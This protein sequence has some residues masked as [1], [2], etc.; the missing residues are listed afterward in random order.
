MILLP[1]SLLLLLLSRLI[2]MPESLPY[3][4]GWLTNQNPC[5][6][7]RLLLLYCI[8]II[9]GIKINFL[10]NLL[11]SFMES[12]ENIVDEFLIFPSELSQSHSDIFKHKNNQR[13]PVWLFSS[14]FRKDSPLCLLSFPQFLTLIN[15]SLIGC[16]TW[17]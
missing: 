15:I 1:L 2:L 17:S 11:Y 16:K 6:V 10:F 4:H 9:S 12:E 5:D 7:T 13:F 3:C 14:T 8:N